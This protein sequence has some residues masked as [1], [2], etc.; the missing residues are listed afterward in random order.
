MVGERLQLRD[1]RSDEQFPVTVS[2]GVL[3]AESVDRSV[4]AD[5]LLLEAEEAVNRAKKAGPNRVEHAEAILGRPVTEARDGP[6]L[7]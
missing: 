1:Y 3:V 6:S 5:Q 7:D 2:V 4:R